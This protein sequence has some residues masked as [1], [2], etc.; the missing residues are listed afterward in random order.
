MIKGKR[1]IIKKKFKEHHEKQLIKYDSNKDGLITLDEY[2]S[3]EISAGP[4][5][6]PSSIN[7]NYQD[8]ENIFNYFMIVFL[9]IKKFKIMCIPNFV[10]K[11]L[12]YANRTALAYNIES[13]E[14]YYSDSMKSSL[15]K[16]AMKDNVRF[17]FFS[18]III[19]KRK[20][21]LTHANMVVIDLL[22]KTY[23]RFEPYGKNM[24]D[25][26]FTKKLDDLF[27]VRIRNLLE[28]HT[29]KYISPTIISPLLG[30]QSVGDSYC[31][32]CITISMMYLHMRILNPDI[33]QP[34]LVKFILNRPTPKLK[35]MILKYAKHVEETLKENKEIVFR[36]FDNLYS[37]INRYF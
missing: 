30:I 13:D 34:K 20:A 29:F 27:Q 11:Y 10:L 14:I 23:E 31:G 9:R 19:P 36:L 26:R 24:Y 4:K 32:M 18:F 5:A 35:E 21:K 28:M 33:E 15:I 17:I 1:K 7:Y 3:K 6:K 8:Y 25:G 37:K 2:L 22:K 12:D 16:C